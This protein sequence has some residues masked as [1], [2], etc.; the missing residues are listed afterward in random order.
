[1]T[2]IPDFYARRFN[3]EDRTNDLTCRDC[4]HTHT[5]AQDDLPLPGGMIICP[6]CEL[7]SRVPTLPSQAGM[8]NPVEPDH[9]EGS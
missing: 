4:G 7:E 9:D 6:G 1:M 8:A 2:R 5:V 3:V